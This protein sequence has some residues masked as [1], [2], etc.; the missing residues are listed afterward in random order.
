MKCDKCKVFGHKTCQDVSSGVPKLG[1][2]Q[3]V[4]VVKG[5]PN[6]IQNGEQLQVTSDPSRT[7]TEAILG[8]FD[9]VISQED[10]VLVSSQLVG[11]SGVC[12]DEVHMPGSAPRVTCVGNTS[13]PNKFAVFQLP[14][15]EVLA[16]GVQPDIALALLALAVVPAIVPVD[17]HAGLDSLLALAAVL[18]IV[19]ADF[20]AGLD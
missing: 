19:P 2:Q 17:F 9:S 10:Q 6:R 1:T 15:D 13:D 11:G 14:S 18:A 7:V 8:P 12:L 3:Q 4:W 5:G 16:E 20:H